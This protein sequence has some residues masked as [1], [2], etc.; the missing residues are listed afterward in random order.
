M[1]SGPNE[2]DCLNPYRSEVSNLIDKFFFFFFLHFVGVY[3]EFTTQD[4]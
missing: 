4:P 1:S 3:R 2:I